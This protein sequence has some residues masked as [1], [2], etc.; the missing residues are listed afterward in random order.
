MRA[1][2]GTFTDVYALGATLYFLLTGEK[3]LAAPERSLE[4]LVSPSKLTEGKVSDRVSEAVMRAMAIRP[5][6]RFQTVGEM[7]AGLVRN[8]GK[9][10]GEAQSAMVG[11]G[12]RSARKS[13]VV[14]IWV[15]VL[16]VVFG[17]NFFYRNNSETQPE[18]PATL[19]A[20]TSRYEPLADQPKKLDPPT[21]PEVE[22]QVEKESGD[23]KAEITP[24][25]KAEQQ[26]QPKGRKVEESSGRE[27]EKT[28]LSS[29]VQDI[30][31]NV[32]RTVR[33]GNQVWMAENLRTTRF[34][35][36]DKIPGNLSDDQWS[37]TTSGAQ[38]VYENNSSNLSTY[39]RL[40]NWYAV[41]D[42]R[43]LCPAGWH[44]P[45]DAEW[46]ELERSLGGEEVAGTA[47]KS[48]KRDYPAWDGSNTSGFSGLPGGYRGYASGNFRDQGVSGNWWSSSPF[49][50]HAWYRDLYSGNSSV[51]RVSSSAGNGFSVRCVR[52]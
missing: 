4:E 40:Y 46:T 48:S 47:M 37:S 7:R 2:R 18:L 28:E 26:E 19:S 25:V 5:G 32:Y 1:Q 33:I 52:D 44:V 11:K 42:S 30:D 22:V 13:R 29:K 8:D 17:I 34:R 27:A 36:G 39:G 43:G 41:K 31:G 38:A 14:A 3:P 45:S 16:L 23:Q 21:E 12:Q 15:G 35:N 51:H 50:S 24:D 9:R 10:T 6:D 49:G 20:D